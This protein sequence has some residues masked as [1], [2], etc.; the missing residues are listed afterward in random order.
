MGLKQSGSGLTQAVPGPNAL[1]TQVPVLGTS[2]PCQIQSRPLGVDSLS[3]QSRLCLG[4]S[5]P[6]PSKS[7][8]MWP[9]L[10]A[11]VLG[12]ALWSA[13]FRED[14]GV[15]SA[16]SAHVRGRGRAGGGGRRSRTT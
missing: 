8:W 5:R 16:S 14:V 13:I 15:R 6:S 9:E 4:G 10:R 12:G 2:T 3:P 11:V 1:E 7:L